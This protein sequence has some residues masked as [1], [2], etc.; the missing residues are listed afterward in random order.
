MLQFKTSFFLKM[1]QCHEQSTARLRAGLW[2]LHP[3]EPEASDISWDPWSMKLHCSP[4]ILLHQKLTLRGEAVGKEHCCAFRP[5]DR[6]SFFY[7]NLPHALPLFI[8]FFFIGVTYRIAN[9]IKR[10]KKKLLVLMGYDLY[11][12]LEIIKA[13]NEMSLSDYCSFKYRLIPVSIHPFI[14]AIF[15]RTYFTDTSL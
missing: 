10:G 13:V 9:C 6:S 4:S 7:S 8:I 3:C 14:E 5:E 1:L 2:E 15:P 12:D 11:R